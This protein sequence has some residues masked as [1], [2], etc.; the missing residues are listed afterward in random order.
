M[1]VILSV[2]HAIRL[3]EK[4]CRESLAVYPGAIPQEKSFEFTQNRLPGRRRILITQLNANALAIT[5]LI[6]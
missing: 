3:R 2:L 6:L 4:K 1:L 5:R